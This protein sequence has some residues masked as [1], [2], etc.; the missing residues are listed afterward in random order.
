ME[1]AFDEYFPAEGADKESLSLRLLA[2]LEDKREM[3]KHCISQLTASKVGQ[4]ERIS[5]RFKSFQVAS[6]QI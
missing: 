1:E 6:R 5:S 2:R 3:F 4:K